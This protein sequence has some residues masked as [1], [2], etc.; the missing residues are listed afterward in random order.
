MRE[1]EHDALAQASQARGE[2]LGVA[3]ERGAHLGALPG[4]I[5]A[6]LELI[7]HGGACGGDALGVT[8][9]PLGALE[10]RPE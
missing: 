2:A 4:A 8:G 3:G 1:G 7:H 10:G 6:G 9:Q 5:G